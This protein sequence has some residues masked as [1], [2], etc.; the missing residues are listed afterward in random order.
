MVTKMMNQEKRVITRIASRMTEGFWRISVSFFSL[1]RKV[2]IYILYLTSI[3][4][5]FSRQDDMENYE[6]PEKKKDNKIDVQQ[7]N[8]PRDFK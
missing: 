7:A 8:N 4:F 3:I 2:S 5:F 6:Y 1:T